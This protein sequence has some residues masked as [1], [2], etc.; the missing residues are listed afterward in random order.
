MLLA[1]CNLG[2]SF[3]LPTEKLQSIAKDVS[4][5]GHPLAKFKDARLADV[6]GVVRTPPTL[7]IAIDYQPPMT[8][9]IRTMVVRFTVTDLEKCDVRTTVVSDDGPPPILLDNGIASPLVGQAV[10]EALKEER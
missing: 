3:S 8:K 5:V 9:H 10:C 6:T 4:S 2:M 7:D 1:A